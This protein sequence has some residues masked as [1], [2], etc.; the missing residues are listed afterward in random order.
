MSLKFIVKEYYS[1][2]GIDGVVQVPVDPEF[3][4]ER[5]AIFITS[6]DVYQAASM[7]NIGSSAMLFGMRCIWES[8]HPNSRQL[9]KFFDTEHLSIGNDESK[10]YTVD[11]IAKWMM[12][13][14]RRG[15]IYFI[16]WIVDRHWMLV[17]VMMRG[18]TI[19]LDPLK[20]HKSPP[21]ITEVM[22]KAYAQ[23]LE[24]EY[25]GTFTKL[26]RGSCPKQPESHECGY[27]VLRY[28]YDL[29]NA[30][31]PA[32][33]IKKKWFDKK[34]FNVKDDLLPLQSDW[35]ARLMPFVYEN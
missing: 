6:E 33:V 23:C 11:L 5:E 2:K 20:N 30:P 12:T 25:I 24:N 27:Y 29:V 21:I 26:V 1:N 8:M 10:N 31:N 22:E 15:Q 13:M 35:L 17:L 32:E 14:D 4:G 34:Q 16:P 19:I 3:I 28:I 18:M 7:D 9:Y